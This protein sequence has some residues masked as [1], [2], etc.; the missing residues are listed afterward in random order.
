MHADELDMDN[1]GNTLSLGNT[2][3]RNKQQPSVLGAMR[4]AYTSITS[5]QAGKRFFN[6][7]VTAKAE[8]GG[9]RTST[10]SLD[11]RQVEAIEMVIQP[12]DE[13]EQEYTLEFRMNSGNS[14]F[15]TY[16]SDD[17]TMALNAG[18]KALHVWADCLKGSEG[19]SQ[20]NH[21]NPGYQKPHY[22]K[23][24]T[25]TRYESAPAR[26]PDTRYGHPN[27]GNNNYSPF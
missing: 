8:G 13:N 1:T 5:D 19:H 14:I 27:S 25:S 12:N 17:A 21:H 18:V 2:S 10:I 24:R 20:G 4:A 26:Q 6:V 15:V 22:K 3:E 7:T 11:M 9:S 23:E 16:D